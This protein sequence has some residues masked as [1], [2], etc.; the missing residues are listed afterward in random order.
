W[1]GDER[2]RRATIFVEVN[3]TPGPGGTIFAATGFEGC[4]TGWIRARMIA[5]P[6]RTH[7]ALVAQERLI[8]H[9]AFKVYASGFCQLL[10]KLIAQ[11]AGL[12]DLDAALRQFT[13]LERAIGNT[14]EAVHFQTERTKDILDL[15]VLAFA[16]AERDPGIGAL[17][18]F[19]RCGDR[20][21]LYALD[22]NPVL[23][24]IK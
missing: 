5:I 11:H 21:V 22:G 20:T 12:H 7:R 23:E 8:G 14:D 4:T 16:K 15:T 18:A 2:F 24:A 17:F 3:P 10:A 13:E 1:L 6:R 19:Q 9:F